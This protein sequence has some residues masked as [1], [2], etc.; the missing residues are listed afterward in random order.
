MAEL[1]EHLQP[2]ARV[3]A[4]P[5]QQATLT[6][7]EQARRPDG[8]RVR[9]ARQRLEQRHLAEELASP[10]AVELDVATVHAPA[11]H[12]PAALDDEHLA[13]WLAGHHDDLAVGVGG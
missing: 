4:E 6:E 2:E 7:H 12:D 10:E 13:A 3:A 5:E 1:L 9:V 8:A 11:D